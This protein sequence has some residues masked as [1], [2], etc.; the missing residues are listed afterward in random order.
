MKIFIAFL[1]AIIIAQVLKMFFK[2]K[3]HWKI[4]VEFGGM[5][6]AHVAGVSA[7]AASLYVLEGLS[8]LFFVALIFSLIV[9]RDAMGVR[10]AVSLNSR[11][12][13][14]I[15]KKKE[16]KETTGH[17]FYEVLGG[18]ILGLIVG[19]MVMII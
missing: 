14:K 3:F 17:T 8:V 9:I 1:A 15:L 18:V 12:I 4:L 6:S 13:N 19:G 5:P 10:K 2:K 11:T 7:M 16:L